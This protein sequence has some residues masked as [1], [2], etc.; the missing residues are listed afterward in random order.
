MNPKSN[1]E[2]NLTVGQISIKEHLWF[3]RKNIGLNV[4]L[5]LN[6][7]ELEQMIIIPEQIKL[8]SEIK[9]SLKEVVGEALRI[10]FS[11]S[12]KTCNIKGRA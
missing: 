12:V 5:S 2:D 10:A 4:I 1:S 3:K 9:K 11:E 7:R 8:P 6:Q